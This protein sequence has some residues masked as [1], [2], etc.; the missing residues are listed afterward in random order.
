M[1]TVKLVIIVRLYVCAGMP[2]CEHKCVLM[3]TLVCIYLGN[4]QRIVLSAVPP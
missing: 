1:E 3:I 4:K 2:G